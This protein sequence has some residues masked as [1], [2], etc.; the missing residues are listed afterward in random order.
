MVQYI[1]E[2]PP[3]ELTIQIEVSDPSGQNSTGSITAS[4]DTGSTRCCVPIRLVRQLGLYPTGYTVVTLVDQT[5]IPNVPVF[6][7]LVHIQGLSSDPKAVEALGLPVNQF[8]LGMDWCN[9]VDIRYGPDPNGTGY[10]L[11]IDL[12]K[13][14]M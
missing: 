3:R 8:I 14:L 10:L 5:Q 2:D 9:Q 1:F 11:E 12:P 7:C 13:P 4:I 6:A